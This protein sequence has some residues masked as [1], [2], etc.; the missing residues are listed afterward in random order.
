MMIDRP[1]TDP[2]QFISR[3]FPGGPAAGSL[4]CQLGVIV[5]PD[6]LLWF[7]NLTPFSENIHDKTH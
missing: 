6:T 1:L 3:R 5:L 4:S 7:L 2:C